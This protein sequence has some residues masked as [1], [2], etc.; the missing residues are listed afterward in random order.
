[1]SLWYMQLVIGH[2]LELL[3]FLGT[4]AKSSG[5]APIGKMSTV[6]AIITCG[7]GPSSAINESDW[8][9]LQKIFE[10]L[11]RLRQKGG[12]KNENSGIRNS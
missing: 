3:S 6:N 8:L 4:R 2:D 7:F 1:M 9:C 12:C 11:E 5:F 10:R